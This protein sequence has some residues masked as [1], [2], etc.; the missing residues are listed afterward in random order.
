MTLLMHSGI[1]DQ[2]ALRSFG[3]PV[4]Q[5]LPGVRQNFQDHAGIGCLWDPPEFPPP[6]NNAAE[7][8]F[9]WKS[10]SS[11]ETPDLQACQGEIP[12][13]SIETA[14]QFTPPANSWTMLAG[15]VRPKSRGRVCLSGPDPDDP[16]RIEAN[17]LS[18]PDDIEAALAGVELAAK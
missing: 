5:H 17:L 3:I 8:T 9:F 2:S 10:Q 11:R 16:M 15:V 13:P 18:H 12:I 7:V 14:A 1:G 4:V 6:R